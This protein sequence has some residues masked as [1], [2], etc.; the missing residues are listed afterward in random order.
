MEKLNFNPRSREGSDTYKPFFIIERNKFQSTLPRRERLCIPQTLP[1]CGYF[2][3]RSREGSDFFPV[4][5][6]VWIVNFNPRSREGSD[7]PWIKHT[8]VPDISIHA[9]AKG[10]TIR[11]L[12]FHCLCE[13]QSTLPRRE[14]P[15]SKPSTTNTAKFQSTLPRRERRHSCCQSHTWIIYFNPRSREGSD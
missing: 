14:R 12:L 15:I 7:S 3:P 10:A 5:S 6:H 8:D 2:N 1:R 11:T 13:F 4:L 9:P